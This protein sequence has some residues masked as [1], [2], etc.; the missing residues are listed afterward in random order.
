MSIASD[1]DVLTALLPALNVLLAAH[2]DCVQCREHWLANAN[3]AL[4][5]MGAAYRFAYPLHDDNG[6]RLE[7]PQ[8]VLVKAAA[9]VPEQPF[10]VATVAPEWDEPAVVKRSHHKK[11]SKKPV[12]HEA[13]D[14]LLV[15]EVQAVKE[16]LDDPDE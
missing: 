2:G 6:V 13:D 10:V 12:D 3:A 7:M 8:L 9:V 4:A 11:V 15:E 16:D 1:K 5:E 14:S